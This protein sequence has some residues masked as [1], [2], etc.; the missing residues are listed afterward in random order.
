MRKFDSYAEELRARAK[1]TALTRLDGHKEEFG[2][3]LAEKG[4]Y[5]RPDGDMKS[6]L[7]GALLNDIHYGRAL[8]EDVRPVVLGQQAVPWLPANDAI[9][10]AD[11]KT[12]LIMSE[13]TKNGLVPSF[14]YDGK[15]VYKK[16]STGW[17]KVGEADKNSAGGA[18]NITG[19]IDGL[20]YHRKYF[21]V[22][23]MFT[24][25]PLNAQQEDGTIKESEGGVLN[26]E[27]GQ[28]ALIPGNDRRGNPEFD[29]SDTAIGGAASGAEGENSGTGDAGG[30]SVQRSSKEKIS[31]RISAITGQSATEAQIKAFAD[32]L[33]Q[34]GVDGNSIISDADLHPG[35]RMFQ[36]R[37]EKV[38]GAAVT[39]VK[40]NPRSSKSGVNF[41]Y[42][43]EL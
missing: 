15:N 43:P 22:R 12:F 25:N 34:F 35:A 31:A 28:Q 16:Y 17:V 20:S 5:F 23:M 38:F 37:F 39:F 11:D 3:E 27:S 1:G 32:G 10:L 14:G 19:R 9:K 13:F 36:K 2:K 42:V 7:I 21:N 30:E 24:D 6:V 18:G 41:R 40:N 4:D 29:N 8:W 26:G 33:A